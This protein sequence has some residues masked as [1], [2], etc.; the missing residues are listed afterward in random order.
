[1]HVKSVYMKNI[2]LR[3]VTLAFVLPYAMYLAC[4][5]Y[6]AFKAFDKIDNAPPSDYVEL[7]VKKPDQGLVIANSYKANGKNPVSQFEY[8]NMFMTVYKIDVDS[9]K[10]IDQLVSIVKSTNN[11]R[12]SKVF[13]QTLQPVCRL[14]F[15]SAL[16]SVLSSKVTAYVN[17][18][19]WMISKKRSNVLLCSGK[20]NEF[21]L[22]HFS[23]NDND[24]EVTKKAAVSIP[25]SMA[26]VKSNKSVYY[27]MAT[28]TSDLGIITPEQLDDIIK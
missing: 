28:A 26:F 17:A 8:R 21:V 19:S 4:Q 6:Q 18:D 14:G 25:C 22:K 23:D 9:D 5:F 1:M 12:D 2:T 10:A 27:I 15:R 3:R 11:F 16:P 24:I 7:F 13:T 20:V